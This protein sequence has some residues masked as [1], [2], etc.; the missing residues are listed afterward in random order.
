MLKKFFAVAMI[1][2]CL[3]ACETGD[4]DN[5]M[6][7]GN[8]NNAAA[9]P[10]PP[11]ATCN[12][13]T[14]VNVPFVANPADNTQGFAFA[15]TDLM[16]TNAMTGDISAVNP[17]GAVTGGAGGAMGQVLNATLNVN[18]TNNSVIT[19]VINGSP[20]NALVQGATIPVVGPAGPPAGATQFAVINIAQA[21]GGQASWLGAGGNIVLTT[22]APPVG[23]AAGIT[24][25]TLQGVCFVP[26]QGSTAQGTFTLNGVAQ[27][28]N[29][30]NAGGL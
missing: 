17:G 19:I 11:A 9:P 27:S 28:A 4:G 24:G 3:A 29:I 16:G 22:L 23:N 14:V 15:F 12:T 1:L 8:A 21:V 25:V 10:P 13:G 2:V 7:T 30:I 6:T 20:G 5:P 18:A 26:N